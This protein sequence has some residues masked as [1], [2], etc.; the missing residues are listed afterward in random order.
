[1][2]LKSYGKLLYQ[3]KS[4]KEAEGNLEKAVKVCKDSPKNSWKQECPESYFQLAL[5]YVQLKK[6]NQAVTAFKE[7]VE[8]DEERGAYAQKCRTNL[9]SYQ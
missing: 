9:K 5:T 6:R 2:S 4:Y 1:M 3:Q 7:C 8:A